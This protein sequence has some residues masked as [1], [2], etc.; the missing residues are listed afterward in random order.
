M[1]LLKQFMEAMNYKMI[2]KAKN[3]PD[4]QTFKPELEKVLGKQITSAQASH[5]TRVYSDWTKG[6][7]YKN[8]RS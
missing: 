7:M 1:I 2:L 8:M 4:L 6:S 5:G 3:F